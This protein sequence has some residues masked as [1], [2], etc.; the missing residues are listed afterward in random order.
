MRNQALWESGSDTLLG[1]RYEA[2]S[3]AISTEP[4]SAQIDLV[5]NGATDS[6]KSID[7]AAFG[8]TAALGDIGKISVGYESKE[9]SMM[10]VTVTANVAGANPLSID[11]DGINNLDKVVWRDENQDRAKV[12]GA[13]LM[14][15]YMIV[16][17]TSR[18][19][20]TE[21]SDSNT[22]VLRQDSDGKF[23]ENADE[24]ISTAGVVTDACK[25]QTVT[26]NYYLVK[27]EKA[28]DGGDAT[29]NDKDGVTTYTAQV[30][31]DVAGTSD[32]IKSAIEATG[33][34]TTYGAKKTHV[35]AEFG[36]GAVTLGLGHS[37]KESND[38]SVTEKTKINYLGL[39]GSLGDTGLN[40]LTWGRSIEA[41]DGTKTNPWMVGINKSL[42]GGAFTFVEHTNKDDDTGGTTHVAFGVNF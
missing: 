25:A 4:V 36:L 7:A 1:G 28:V 30:G 39:Q 41:P 37:Q 12:K 23:Y 21:T 11:K 17:V 35:S 8:M 40:W 14:D 38:P 16:Q 33:I 5:M 20:L 15:G 29:A 22:N 3:Y 26:K 42:G 27:V 18:S 19:A 9:D 6:G 2:L 13:G 34:G 10:D 32:L 24:C 31:T